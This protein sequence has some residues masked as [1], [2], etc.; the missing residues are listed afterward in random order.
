MSHRGSAGHASA[1]APELSPNAPRTTSL[2]DLDAGGAA[3]GSLVA[4]RARAVPGEGPLGAPLALVG[5]QP[6]DVEDL[7][8]RQLVGP[9]GHLLDRAFAAA[10]IAR[11]DCYLTNAVKHFKFAQRGKRRIRQKPTAGEVSHYRGWLE[12]ALELAAPRLVVAL[13]TTALLA[14]AG[15]ALTIS[16]SR[17]R[18]ASRA[19][20]RLRHSASLIGAQNPAG[21]EDCGFCSHPGRSASGAGAVRGGLNRRLCQPEL[22]LRRTNG[23]LPAA[24]ALFMGSQPSHEE[25]T[26]P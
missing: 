9:A 19:L 20:G 11:K 16:S 26:W 14:P 6:G 15:K 24:P 12:A 8:G 18:R 3:V 21:E 2:A 22:R 10:N 17:G 1:E 7:A 4:G 25:G 23:E 13:G 5:E